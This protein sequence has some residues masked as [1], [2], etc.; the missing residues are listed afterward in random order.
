MKAEL[1]K[2]KSDLE[3]RMLNPD[4]L[5]QNLTSFYMGW[6]QFLNGTRDLNIEKVKCEETFNEFMQAQF[7][8]TLTLN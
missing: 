6:R 4:A 8:I 5:S 7:N 1:E 3:S 2:L